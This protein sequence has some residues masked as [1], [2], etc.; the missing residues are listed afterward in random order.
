[1]SEWQPIKTAPKTRDGLLLTDGTVVTQGGWLSQLDQGAEYEGQCGAPS[2]G[3]WS[4]DFIEP[5]HWMAMP[6][7]PSP[8]ARPPDSATPAGQT[9]VGRPPAG[10]APSH[11]APPV[12]RP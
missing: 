7:P 3:W 10:P 2:A 12:P 6:P 1:M 8:E 5:T 11:S 9:P 4:V